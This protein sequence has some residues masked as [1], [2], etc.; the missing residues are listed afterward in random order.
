MSRRDDH[1]YPWALHREE[2]EPLEQLG[3]DHLDDH[4][5]TMIDEIVSAAQQRQQRTHERNLE[6]DPGLAIEM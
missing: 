5:R 6:L 2:P 1:E 4:T 3:I